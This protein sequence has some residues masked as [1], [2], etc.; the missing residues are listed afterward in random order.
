MIHYSPY[1]TRNTTMF[2][3]LGHVTGIDLHDLR[4]MPDGRC[5]R[6]I[7]FH[8]ETGRPMTLQLHSTI[9]GALDMF[10]MDSAGRPT[11]RG[12]P[13]CTHCDEPGFDFIDTNGNPWHDSC[14]RAFIAEYNAYYDRHDAPDDDD[15]DGYPTGP[16]ICADELD[17]SAYDDDVA[18]DAIDDDTLQSLTDDPDDV[19]DRIDRRLRSVANTWLDLLFN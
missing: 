13:C 12:N 8:T 10:R 16:P 17:C 2:T 15:W 7:T 5:S 4:T 9:S 3:I 18:D 11:P 19:R 6:R 14:H 1:F